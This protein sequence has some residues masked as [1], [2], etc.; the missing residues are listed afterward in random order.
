LL[1]SFS[2]FIFFA[3]KKGVVSVGDGGLTTVLNS[4]LGVPDWVFGNAW[5]LALA[6]G[7]A[8]VLRLLVY[9]WRDYISVM[10]GSVSFSVEIHCYQRKE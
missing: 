6:L 2:P 3:R 8:S 10:R 5:P 1:S 9:K 7:D 4:L